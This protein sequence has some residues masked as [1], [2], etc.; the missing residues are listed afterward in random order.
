MRKTEK[1]KKSKDNIEKNSTTH[2]KPDSF[3]DTNKSTS[4]ARENSAPIKPD[5]DSIFPIVGIGASAGGLEAL[6]KI[7]INMPTDSGMAFVIVMHF[8]PTAKSGSCDLS[9]ETLIIP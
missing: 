8:D 7:F 3:K 6:E 2:K 5:E 4:P 9:I 1:K